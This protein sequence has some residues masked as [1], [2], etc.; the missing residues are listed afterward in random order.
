MAAKVAH[1]QPLP[2]GVGPNIGAVLQ[3]LNF[4]VE[5]G[6]LDVVVE[7]PSALFSVDALHRQLELESTVTDVWVGDIPRV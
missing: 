5:M 7:G 2:R 4:G 1:I 6:F 3:A